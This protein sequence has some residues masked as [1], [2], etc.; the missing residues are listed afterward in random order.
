MTVQ[1]ENTL[2][3]GMRKLMYTNIILLRVPSTHN[4]TQRKQYSALVEHFVLPRNVNTRRHF[5]TISK[6]SSSKNA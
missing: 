2:L 5:D 1:K 4:C 3:C 6:V